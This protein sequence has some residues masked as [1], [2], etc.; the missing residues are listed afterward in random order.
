MWPRCALP[1]DCCF[2][3]IA[4]VVKPKG[5][6]KKR[7]EKLPGRPLFGLKSGMTS[8]VETGAAGGLPVLLTAEGYAE[9][10]HDGYQHGVV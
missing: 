3:V 4:K 1:F 6:A 5:G 9:G 2:A 10:G 7:P 8:V